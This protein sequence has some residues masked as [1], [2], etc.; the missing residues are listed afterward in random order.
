MFTIPTEA[1]LGLFS[2]KSA[3]HEY[4]IKAS[5]PLSSY[6]L[7]FRDTPNMRGLG[8]FPTP[9]FLLPTHNH[10]TQPVIPNRNGV[11]GYT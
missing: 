2:D 10:T 1:T 5:R 3:G 9:P 4:Q 7:H 11:V 8:G 6:R